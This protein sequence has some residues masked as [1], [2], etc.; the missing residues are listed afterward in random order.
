M[1][2]RAARNTPTID[3]SAVKYIRIV[4]ASYIMAVGLGVISGFDANAYFSVFLSAPASL[5]A[6]KVFV[7]FCASMLFFGFFLR[8]VSLCL[9][10][11]I[12]AS[13]VQVNLMFPVQGSLDAFWVD[14]VLICSLLAS[15]C[16]LS[17]RQLRNQAMICDG[18]VKRPT[19]ISGGVV[20]P[21]RVTL[22]RKS[23]IDDRHSSK[24]GQGFGTI[25][26]PSEQQDLLMDR[27]A[28]LLPP[29]GET[30]D[31]VQNIFA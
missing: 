4:I 8:I 27:L 1:R 30:K 22:P 15:Y 20:V 2:Y 29:Q 28:N 14:L 21:R 6:S 17:A 19:L 24:F 31:E 23:R 18:P 13:S 3:L 5:Y 12:L 25:A 26:T 11:V 10:I 16:P 9:A 7:I